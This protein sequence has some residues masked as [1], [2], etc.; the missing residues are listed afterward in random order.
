M[1]CFQQNDWRNLRNLRTQTSLKTLSLFCLANDAHSD[2]FGILC[3]AWEEF[4]SSPKNV[5]KYLASPTK[6]VAQNYQP[7][8]T[9]SNIFATSN[10]RKFIDPFKQIIAHEEVYTYIFGFSIA[11]K[12]M[13]TSTCVFHC[14]HSFFAHLF[15]TFFCLFCKFFDYQPFATNLA[16]ELNSLLVHPIKHN[17]IEIC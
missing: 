14:V 6:N 3:F 9:L 5:I 4:L 16:N 2:Q 15:P 8:H 17:Q 11:S 13:N 10:H 1:I 7:L 12:L